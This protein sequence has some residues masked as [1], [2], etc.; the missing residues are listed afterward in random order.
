MPRVRDTLRR[1]PRPFHALRRPQVAPAGRLEEGVTRLPFA[2]PLRPPPDNPD[3]PLFETYHG[4][5]ISVQACRAAPA[6]PGRRGALT[7]RTAG[8]TAWRRR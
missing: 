6:L 2:L 3:T 1:P 5:N 8:S 4:I 7:R